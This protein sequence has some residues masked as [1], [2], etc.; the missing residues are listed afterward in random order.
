M[1]PYL[2]VM[3]GGDQEM[4]RVV[5]LRAVILILCG[6]P[7]TAVAIDET[8]IGFHYIAVN[9][10]M[11]FHLCITALTLLAADTSILTVGTTSKVVDIQ[12][13]A[14]G[15]P[16]LTSPTLSIV[17]NNWCSSLPIPGTGNGLSI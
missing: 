9:L 11:V 6:G 8:T 15:Q 13:G 16:C 14:T 5:E 3:R 10:Y 12:I 4:L 1:V 2:C 7:V 17:H